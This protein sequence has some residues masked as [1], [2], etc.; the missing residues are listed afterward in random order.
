MAQGLMAEV[1]RNILI[2]SCDD[3]MPLD[4][5]AVKR[6]CR[7]ADVMAAHQLCRLELEKFRKAA[8]GRRAAYRRLH[9]GSAAVLPKSRE[10]ADIR[11]VNIRETAGWSKDAKA[12][13]PKIAALIAAAAE[14]VADIP[15][16][17]FESEGVILIYGRDEAAIEAAEP[18]QGSSRR[19]RAD[20]AAG[21]HRAAAHH[22]IPGG[23]GHDPFRQGPSRRVRADCRRLCAAGA[24]VARRAQLSGRRRTARPRAATS[25]STS[26]AARRCSPPPI[27]ATAICAPIPA[28]PPR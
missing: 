12:A 25:S 15:F 3:T 27:C 19:H 16:V 20:Q 2:C 6:A 18:A 14:P 8:A 28:T 17:S 26:R 4:E 22:R 10:D 11:F 7:G 13:G 21:R 5:G 23:E 1:P 9:A 24:V